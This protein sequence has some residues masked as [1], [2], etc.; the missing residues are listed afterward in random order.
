MYLSSAAGV[1]NYRSIRV[2]RAVLLIRSNGRTNGSLRFRWVKAPTSAKLTA[3]A[4]TIAR[5]VGRYLERRGLIERDA[6]TTYLS[7]EGADEDPMH[8]LRGD[9]IAYRISVG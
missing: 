8:Q 9:S 1:I 2:S 3:L 5:R 4:H 6:E 7:F